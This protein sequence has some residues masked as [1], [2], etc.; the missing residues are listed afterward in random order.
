M[1]AALGPGPSHGPEPVP[2]GTQADS[3]LGEIHKDLDPAAID[4]YIKTQNT[5]IDS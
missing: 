5:Y 4:R 2:A 1:A 3:V